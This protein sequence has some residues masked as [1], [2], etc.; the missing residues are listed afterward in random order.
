MF[1]R[2]FKKTRII[3]RLYTQSNPNRNSYFHE[4]LE[5]A[6]QEILSLIKD[7]IERQKS[8]L[9]LIASENYTS[10]AVMQC[11][12]TPTQNKYSEGFPGRRVYTGTQ[13]I[14][15]IENLAK[16][17]A[18]KLF[19]LNPEEW[20][21]DVQ[22]LSGCMA[23]SIA[24]SSVLEVGD[25]VLGMHLS[26]GGHIS[27]GLKVG[28]QALSHTAKMYNWEHYGLDEQ[29]WLDYDQMEKVSIFVDDN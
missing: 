17:R 10:R 29:G 15:K 3:H 25:K 27:H 16:E 22:C 7:E 28:N 5:T 4:K 1:S 8:N 11:L 12:G 20:E 14:D 9:N 6:D 2:L 21:V 18:L 26:D 23:N 13:I 24:Y 19:N